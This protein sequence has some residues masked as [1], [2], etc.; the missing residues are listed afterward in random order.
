MYMCMCIYH[1][2]VPH[3]LHMHVHMHAHIFTHTRTHAHIHTRWNILY[4]MN[5]YHLFSHINWTRW[6]MVSVSQGVYKQTLYITMHAF[7]SS[8]P[9][10]CDCS[11]LIIFQV[12][13][14]EIL[15]GKCKDTIKNN[16]ERIKQMTSDHE[17]LQHKLEERDSVI[18]STK[19]QWAL[20]HCH[21]D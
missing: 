14:L 10:C 1:I 2:H 21:N 5:N 18:N 6:I 15:L 3:T 7:L 19:V 4:Y 17:E 16:K 20:W 13:R 9:H 12:K 8:I 11:L